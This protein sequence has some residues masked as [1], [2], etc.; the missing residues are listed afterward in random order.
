MLLTRKAAPATHNREEKVMDDGEQSHVILM[1]EDAL[2]F[3]VSADSTVVLRAV[4]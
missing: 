4:H 2:L 3:A 1:D